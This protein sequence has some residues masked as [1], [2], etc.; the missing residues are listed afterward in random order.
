MYTASMCDCC[1]CS[2][3]EN[4]GCPC[5]DDCGKCICGGFCCVEDEEVIIEE[6]ESSDYTTD[7]DTGERIKASVK[8]MNKPKRFSLNCFR[9]LLKWACTFA[10]IDFY[11]IRNQVWICFH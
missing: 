2:C 5:C 9:L 3:V 8:Q 10:P 4:C 11:L 1:N 7:S 6:V